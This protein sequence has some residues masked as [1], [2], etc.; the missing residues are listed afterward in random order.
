MS[1]EFEWLGPSNAPSEMQEHFGTCV[2]SLMVSAVSLLR[3]LLCTVLIN[4]R[5]THSLT[6][7]LSSRRGH[8]GSMSIL[9]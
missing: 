8:L 3:V 2:R 7:L 4:S 9:Y 1:S 5:S 6:L